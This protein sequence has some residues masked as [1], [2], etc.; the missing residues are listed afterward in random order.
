[1]RFLGSSFVGLHVKNSPKSS[2][3]KGFNFFSRLWH[4]RIP[5]KM[6]ATCRKT[7]VYLCYQS[8]QIKS[9]VKQAYRYKEFSYGKQSLEVSCF[10]SGPFFLPLLFRRRPPKFITSMDIYKTEIRHKWRTQLPICNTRS[11]L[12]CGPFLEEPAGELRPAGLQPVFRRLGGV[13]H[14]FRF[15]HLHFNRDH[16]LILHPLMHLSR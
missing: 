15:H 11:M 3:S 7:A 14:Q 5:M 2:T 6:S 16:R 12:F 13:I 4:D 9:L 10:Y 1:M 8:D